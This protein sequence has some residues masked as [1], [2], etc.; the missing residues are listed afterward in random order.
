MFLYGKCH[1]TTQCLQKENKLY[2]NT[3]LSNQKKCP[4]IIKT[5][6]EA[7]LANRCLRATDTPLAGN[8]IFWRTV[9]D[10]LRDEEV[11]KMFT[12][13]LSEAWDN[14]EFDTRSVTLGLNKDIGWENTDWIDNYT[15]KD[16]ER[17]EPN[18]KS[19]ALRIKSSC[20]HILAPRTFELTFVY[21]FIFFNNKPKVYIHS[22]YPGYDIGELIG[23]ITKLE[24]RIFFDWDHPGE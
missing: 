20:K 11:F 15:E 19:T 2:I 14:N 18:R 10:V 23:D 9:G 7:R 22:M 12:E 5:K 3:T 6:V 4:I 8:F 16:L 13:E 1:L 17:F 24:N 21:Q